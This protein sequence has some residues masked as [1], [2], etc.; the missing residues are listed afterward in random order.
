MMND[1]QIKQRISDFPATCRQAGLKVTPQRSAIFAMLTATD[2]H[3]SP[4]EVYSA[5]L[6]TTPSISLATVYKILDL[7]HLQGFI[8]RISTLDQVRRYDAN[9]EPHHHLM[10]SQ[11]GKIRDLEAG[12]LSDKAAGQAPE[13]PKVPDF[14]VSGYEVQFHGICSECRPRA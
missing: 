14:E 8:R 5:I 13:I 4:E 3:P 11:C 7:F 1:A 6:E 10:C 9:V 12:A 2:S